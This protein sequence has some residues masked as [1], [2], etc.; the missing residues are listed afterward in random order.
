L[1][2]PCRDSLTFQVPN[3]ISFFH[4][5]GHAKESVQV[6]GT[7]KHFVIYYFLWWRVVS[8]TPNPQAGGPPLAGCPRLRIQYIHSYSLYLEAFSSICNLRTHHAV[9]T[10]DP[11]NMD[12]GQ[13]RIQ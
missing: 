4:W 8:L 12:P 2:L 10:R 7:L 6:Q 11:P 13:Y 9:V 5:L 1:H 3:L